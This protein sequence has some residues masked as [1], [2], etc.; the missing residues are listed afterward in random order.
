VRLLLSGGKPS[1]STGESF[2]EGRRAGIRMFAGLAVGFKRTAVFV[3]DGLESRAMPPWLRAGLPTA[4]SHSMMGRLEK[5]LRRQTDAERPQYSRTWRRWRPLRHRS[6][7]WISSS[8]KWRYVRGQLA[9]DERYRG[10]PNSETLTHLASR[11][12]L[13]APRQLFEI[14]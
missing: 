2:S 5:I 6:R 14:K 4:S 12:Q 10:W 1:L 8:R 13:I 11:P 7:A 3:I 9:A